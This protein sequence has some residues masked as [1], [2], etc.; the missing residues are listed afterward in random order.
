M[1]LIFN[2]MQLKNPAHISITKWTE[3]VHLELII[4]FSIDTSVIRF[5]TRIGV[6]SI[7]AN[8]PWRQ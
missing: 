1:R 4:F 3:K 5:E 8:V 2:S 6:F 7:Q